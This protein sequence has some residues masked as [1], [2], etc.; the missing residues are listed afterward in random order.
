NGPD[1]GPDSC[2]YFDGGDHP[3]STKPV[4]VVGGLSF[5]ALAVG[6]FHTCARTSAEAAVYCWGRNDKGQ[7]GDGQNWG[8]PAPVVGD[9][10]F[11]DLAAS[12]SHTCGLTTSGAAY[13]WGLNSDGQLGNGSTTNSATPV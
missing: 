1:G 6:G 3:C 10:S 7:L 2:P 13:C 9:L 8:T 12:E 11:S 4:A 5:N